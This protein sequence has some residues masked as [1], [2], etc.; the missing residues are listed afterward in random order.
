MR[1]LYAIQGTGNGHLG[2]ASEII[3][4][5][6]KLWRISFTNNPILY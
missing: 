3:P 2:R 4:S 6:Q 5:L 1:I